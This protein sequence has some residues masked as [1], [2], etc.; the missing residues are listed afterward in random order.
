MQHPIAAGITG[1]VFLALRVVY[2]MGYSTRAPENRA[3]GAVGGA[4]S[5]LVLVSIICK[6][7]VVWGVSLAS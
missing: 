3:T 6:S 5:L 7:I 2:F 4:L 1:L